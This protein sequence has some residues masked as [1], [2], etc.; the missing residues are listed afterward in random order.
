MA[1]LF[2]P[3]LI[4]TRKGQ[5][6]ITHYNVEFTGVCA[7]AHKYPTSIYMCVDAQTTKGYNP[8]TES[9]SVVLAVKR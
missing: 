8:G 6:T 1:K 2:A 9:H 5:L 7:F 3:C 4:Q